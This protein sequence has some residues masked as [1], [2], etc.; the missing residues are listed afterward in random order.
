VRNRPA[1]PHAGDDQALAAPSVTQ[2]TSCDLQDAPG[3]GIDRL[4]DADALDAEAEGGEEQ[5]EDA[6]AHAVIEVVDEAGLRGCE[7]IAV[8][9]RRE[10]KDF[11]KT[12]RRSLLRV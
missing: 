11:P 3:R 12:D 10:R 6:P 9:E 8:L 2:W 4:E 1:N 5:R 7:E